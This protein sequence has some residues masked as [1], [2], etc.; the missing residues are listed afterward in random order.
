MARRLGALAVIVAFAASAS[1]AIAL[2]VPVNAPNTSSFARDI[3]GLW[4]GASGALILLAHDMVSVFDG[5][6]FATTQPSLLSPSTTAI[7]P[8]ASN[9]RMDDDQSRNAP[10]SPL[11]PESTSTA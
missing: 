4:S 3:V 8:T 2:T 5:Q 1:P 7:S 10:I 9:L 11:P 6:K